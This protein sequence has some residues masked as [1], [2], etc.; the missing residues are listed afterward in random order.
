VLCGGGD[1]LHVILEGV[2]KFSMEQ[3]CKAY[4][5][6][7]VLQANR[8]VMSNVTQKKGD[9]LSQ[10]PL[11]HERCEELGIT[12]NMTTLPVDTPYKKVITHFDDFKYASK[13][14]IDLESSR[15]KS[16]ETTV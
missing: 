13:K 12:F 4:S 10:V 15:N 9:F 2:G 16:R 8:S 5:N 6:F 14:V 1:P 3:G 7:A 11:Q